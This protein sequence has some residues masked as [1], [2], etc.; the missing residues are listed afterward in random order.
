MTRVLVTGGSGFVGVPTLRELV[1]L[2]DDV[3]ALTSSADPPAVEGVRWRQADLADRGQVDAAMATVRPE[4]LVH[5]AWYVEP[6][7]FW[8]APENVAWVQHSLALLEAFLRAGGRRAVMLGT[9]AEYDWA[10]PAEFI[11][12]RR[13]PLVP[14]TLY[15]VAKD[16][17]RRV[18]GTYA[19][20]QDAEL[21]WGR[22]FFLYGPREP[23]TRFVPAICRALVAGEPA[24]LTSGAQVRDFLHVD[25]VGGALAALLHAPVTGAVNI[26][27]GE[28]V[29][30]AAVADELGRLAQRP[31][32]IERGALP[33]RRGEPP[34]LV[35]D[36]ARLRDEVG[37][38]P[39]WSLPDGLAD[40]LSWWRGRG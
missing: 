10:E 22:L 2:G 12:E 29:T 14:T 25:D 17:L 9:C 16:A 30:L 40:T 38:R 11:D 36:V 34:R 21:A 19:Q 23:P 18:A 24:Q 3:H 13:Q 33:D 39:R 7:R 6:G 26:A 28:A 20:A 1:R 15:G 37:F 31:E 27:S 5:L 4:Q 35:A 32:L 8:T